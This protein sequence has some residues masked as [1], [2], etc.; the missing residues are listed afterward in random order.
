MLGERNVSVSFY[1]IGNFVPYTIKPSRWMHTVR[2]RKMAADT[3][4]L[5]REDV[6]STFFLCINACNLRKILY[7]K[8]T[9]NP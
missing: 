8:N 2:K 9:N 6:Q 7:N 4:A 1:C 3:A 5:G